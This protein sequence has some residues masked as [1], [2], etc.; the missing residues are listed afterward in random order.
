[1][2]SEVKKLRKQ[3]VSWKRLDDFGLE[4]RFIAKY[5]K[6]E[7]NKQEMIERLKFAIHD[8]ARRQLTW[9]RRD[10]E[11]HWMGS[12]KQGEKLIGKFI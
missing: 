6:G 3:S 8:F 10:K 9:F 12:Q 7:F 2:I 4:Y 11:I 5:L 1:M